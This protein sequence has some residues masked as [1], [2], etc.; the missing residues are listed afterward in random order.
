M[1]ERIYRIKRFVTVRME[2]K[3]DV[4]TLECWMSPVNVWG[5]FEASYPHK[6]KA[7]IN[8]GEIV[9]QSNREM[10][11]NMI[12][13]VAENSEVIINEQIERNKRRLAVNG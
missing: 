7:V 3:Q 12:L 9:I 1:S 4:F 11:P 8:D 13:M 2:V 6:Y 5:N 10:T